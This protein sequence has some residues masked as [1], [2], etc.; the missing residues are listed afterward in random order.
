MPIFL[1][2]DAVK[3]EATVTGH[4]DEIELT[5]LAHGLSRPLSVS[6]EGVTAGPPTVAEIT[7]T[8]WYDRASLPLIQAALT[9]PEIGTARI[10]F[11][12][13]GEKPT[14]YLVLELLEA[15]VLSSTMSSDG[16]RPVEQVT[17][18]SPRMKWTYQPPGMSA[19]SFGY[20]VV[21][22]KSL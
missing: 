14:D 5:S 11:V 10:T 12:K 9:N 18:F 16:D 15:Q 22:G 21:G 4:I 17:F 13:A 20:D 8:K 19:T 2:L 3:G 7:V 1:K 6:P